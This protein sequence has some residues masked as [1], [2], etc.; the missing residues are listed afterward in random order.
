MSDLTV[1]N[2]II[3]QMGGAGKLTAMIGATYFAGTETSVQ[4]CS[5]CLEWNSLQ[6]P[7][8]P[9]LICTQYC[10]LTENHLLSKTFRHCIQNCLTLLSNRSLRILTETLGILLPSSLPCR[11][12]V[13][14]KYP[15]GQL[16]RD[17]ASRPQ[18]FFQVQERI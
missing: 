16:R 2:T 6:L 18:R 8:P 14:S 12:P 7:L 5:Y 17:D 11:Y 1:A 13:A 15:L 3:E 10:L 4:S 9:P